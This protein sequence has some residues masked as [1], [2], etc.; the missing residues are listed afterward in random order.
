MS[1]DSKD[2]LPTGSFRIF[3]A[4]GFLA[5]S[6]TALIYSGWPGAVGAFLAI[7]L[8]FLIHLPYF[9]YVQGYNG[10]LPWRKELIV[11]LQV[12]AFSFITAHVVAFICYLISTVISAT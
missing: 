6:S 12:I 2:S 3:V 11:H 9:L 8:Q 1:R 5:A 10:Q 7:A 4:G